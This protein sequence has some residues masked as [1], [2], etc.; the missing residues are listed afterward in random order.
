MILFFDNMEMKNYKLT[1]NEK[2]VLRLI[3]NGSDCP[4]TFPISIFNEGVRSLE[5][6]GLVKVA[7]IEGGG[8]EA[9]RLTSEGRCLLAENPSL[10]NQTDWKWI[11][12]TGIAVI[13][14]IT[15]IVAFL[16]LAIRFSN[17]FRRHI[18]FYIR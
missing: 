12:A 8:V 2:K 9:V 10:K 18:C 11:I 1:K 4:D 3:A 7:Y 14:A 15:G 6:E 16:W 13:G 5:R 17:L